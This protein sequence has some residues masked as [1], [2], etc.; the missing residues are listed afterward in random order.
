MRPRCLRREDGAAG[1]LRHYAARVACRVGPAAT[2]ACIGPGVC[3]KRGRA[4]PRYGSARWVRAMGP[5]SPRGLS[6]AEVVAG[7]RALASARWSLATRAADTADTDIA[8][9][10]SSGP[11]RGSTPAP[12]S[13][14]SRDASETD[15]DPETDKRARLRPDDDTANTSPL[16][17]PLFSWW[18]ASKEEKDDFEAILAAIDVQ[19]KQTE[20]QIVAIDTRERQVLYAWFY[21]SVPTY[22]LFLLTYLLVLRSPHDAWDRWLAKA[23]P[24]IGVPLLIEGGRRLIRRYFA[25]RRGKLHAVLKRHRASQ[26]EKIEELKRKTAYYKTKGLIERYDA[27]ASPSRPLVPRPGMAP[28][29]SGPP[30]QTAFGHDLA[31]GGAGAPSM[32]PSSAPPSGARPSSGP[33]ASARP[34]PPLQMNST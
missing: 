24:L 6:H 30:A 27:T 14:V 32:A 16:T 12:A 18:R 4:A 3:W 34:L 31:A 21:Y 9:A 2:S 11:R 13:A 15:I 10:W 7:R 20:Q 29:S 8:T 23:A 33:S 28:G 22:L 25:V 19:V 1:L 26:R 5:T 17:M